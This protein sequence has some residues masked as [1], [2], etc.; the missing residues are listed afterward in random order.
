MVP[1]GVARGA[2]SLERPSFASPG[3]GAPVLIPGA[4]RGSIPFCEITPSM[5]FRRTG[6]R[7]R[8]GVRA[9]LLPLCESRE[10]P[11]RATDG[12]TMIAFIILL[13]TACGLACELLLLL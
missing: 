13:E 3:P 7:V 4:L 5:V 8:A 1:D 12:D 2:A 9:G 10:I 6:W 11:E